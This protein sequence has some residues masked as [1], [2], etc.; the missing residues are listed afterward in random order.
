MRYTTIS[1]PALCI[2]IDPV[3]SITVGPLSIHLYGL[4]IAAGLLLAVWYCCRR[5]KECPGS[6]DLVVGQSISAFP[7]W[8][9]TKHR[10]ICVPN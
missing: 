8:Q 4:L 7:T 2:E 9:Q 5:S 3:R 1:F 10:R 6:T